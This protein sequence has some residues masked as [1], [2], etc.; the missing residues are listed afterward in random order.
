[1]KKETRQQLATKIDRATATRSAL[2]EDIVRWREQMKTAVPNPPAAT[3]FTVDVRFS[4]R[5]NTYQ[6]LVLRH[7]D[8]WYTT[9]SKAEHKMFPSW[10]AFVEWLESEEVYSHSDLEV[11]QAAGHAFNLDT[12]AYV[13]VTQHTNVPF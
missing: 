11:L 4:L 7:G 9:G 5:G 8:R 2:G 10:A 12:G 3:M 1:M 13:D 6:F